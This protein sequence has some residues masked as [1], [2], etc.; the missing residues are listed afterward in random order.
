MVCC[1]TQLK[2]FLKAYFERILDFQSSKS[3]CEYHLVFKDFFFLIKED[4]NTHKPRCS[5]SQEEKMTEFG[6]D[7]AI[8]WFYIFVPGVLD[9]WVDIYDWT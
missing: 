9:V 8:F 6:Y 5:R 2:S 1:V 7:K 3:V 4:R